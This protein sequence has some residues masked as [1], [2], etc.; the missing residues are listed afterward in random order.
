MKIAH[1]IGMALAPSPLLTTRRGDSQIKIIEKDRPTT[2]G[3]PGSFLY[4]IT[5]RWKQLEA[6]FERT[7]QLMK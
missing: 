7:D 6:N 2:K 3:L 1:A 4:S 5:T